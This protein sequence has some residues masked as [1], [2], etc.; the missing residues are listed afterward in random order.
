MIDAIVYTSKCGHTYAY[1]KELSQQLNIPMFTL[2]E[3]K[4]HLKKE[5]HIIYMSWIREEKLMKYNKA[6]QYTL[7]C[8]VAVG[9]MPSTEKNISAIISENQ[10]F[11]KL[12]YLP[13]GI[14]KKR[15]GLL[16][17]IKL[18]S[19]E[20]NLSFKLLDNGLSKEDARALDAIL[21]NLDYFDKE[22]LEPILK[23]Y[24]IK[25]DYIS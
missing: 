17:R 5:N 7:E 19:I 13:G 24:L 16:D 20:S 10:L 15:L 25:E 14:S 18:K 3:A 2:K 23:K 11:V 22:A 4:K 8:V 6:L 12:Y 1:A 9:I 21:H